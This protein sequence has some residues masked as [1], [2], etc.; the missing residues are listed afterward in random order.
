MLCIPSRHPQSS[1]GGGADVSYKVN[2][3]RDDE[4][5][6]KSVEKDDDEKASAF[7]SKLKAQG[8]ETGT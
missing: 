7:L 2:D 8:F 1:T 5:L 4:D 3:V 6:G